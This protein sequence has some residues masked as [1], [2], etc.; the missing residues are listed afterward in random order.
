MAKV[1]T[2][3]IWD[4]LIKRK[5]HPE[6]TKLYTV[7]NIFI[8]KNE[9]LK[10]EYKDEIK[11]YNLRLELEAKQ[12]KINEKAGN[13]NECVINE[14][15][16]ELLKTVIKED[17][18]IDIETEVKKL[19]EAEVNFE[20]SVTYINPAIV[21]ILEK[22]KENDK[23]CIS[24][25]YMKKE[26]LEQI[27]KSHGLLKQFKKIYVSADLLKT[28][29]N[30]G[31]LFKH[32]LETENIDKENVIHVGDS[33]HS[34]YD[35]AKKVGIKEIIQIENPKKY[36]FD[37]KNIVN[38]DLNL[39]NMLKESINSKPVNYK[40][41]VTTEANLYNVGIY[42]SPF[43]YFFI[44]D[45]IKKAK[46]KG[47]NKIYY[48]TREGENFLKY[49]NI[50]KENSPF[51]FEVPEGEILEVSRM[52]TFAASLKEFTIGELLRLWSQYRT[53]SMK[54]LF[55]TLN[56][57]ISKYDKYFIKYEI[58]IEEN[59][60][61]P[62]FNFK[63][64]SLFNDKDFKSLMDEELKFKRVKLLEYFEKKGI[65]QDTKKIFIVDIGWRGTIQDNLAY[66][67]QNTQIDG[68]Y[69]G[70]MDFHNFQPE[71]TS[72]HSFIRDKQVLFES[73]GPVITVCEMLHN[74]DT[75]S[76]ISYENGI[77]KRKAKSSETEFVQKVISHIQDGIYE[78]ARYI[79]EL[80]KTRVLFE[81]DYM[82]IANMTIKN[83]KENPKKELVE[84]FFGLIHNETFGL[85]KYIDEKQK[86]TFFE[87]LNVFK[88]RNQ[89]RVEPWKESIIIANDLW[90]IP[91]AM[92]I[93]SKI[94]KLIGK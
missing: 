49:H 12:G 63:V 3:D 40:N 86:M 56:I 16:K 52:A 37:S 43:T 28:K 10:P 69:M 46:E 83:T 18:N 53:Q 9:L 58:D 39:K 17:V 24:D 14:V 68:A 67:F 78:G 57:D 50:I 15:L 82:N 66:I 55:K 92:K 89:L 26:E 6:E 73:L 30:T 60:C 42:F 72:K 76:V 25:F 19:I 27:L 11:I 1:I 44:Y 35:M 2:F 85:G 8:N 47:Y 80:M 31:N 4:T 23:Y 29:R 59:I 34:D 51:P 7:R 62:F 36:D 22:Y 64:I 13:D 45:V 91:L 74:P 90:F 41:I 65:T 5:C 33:K 93:K 87:K 79:N 70:I 21:E 75:G 84:A 81:K 71:N 94:R 54:A 88:I 32:F 38:I 61:E 48:Q 20:I 77:A